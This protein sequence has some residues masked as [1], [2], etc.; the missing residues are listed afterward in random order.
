MNLVGKRKLNSCITIFHKYL[1]HRAVKN[2]IMVH[3]KCV[4]NFRILPI[5]PGD[6]WFSD[7]CGAVERCISC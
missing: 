1:S 4:T 5:I 3:I 7:C 2:A 6:W